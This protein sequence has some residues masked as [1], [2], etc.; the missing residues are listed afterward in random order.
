MSALPPKADIA[1]LRKRV[2]A[3]LGTCGPN[4]NRAAQNEGRHPRV[5]AEARLAHTVAPAERREEN[6]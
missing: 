2:L 6:T 5:E 4:R 3:F 1:H